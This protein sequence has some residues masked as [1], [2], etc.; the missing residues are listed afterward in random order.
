MEGRV[1][2]EVAGGHQRSQE[3]GSSLAFDGRVGEYRAL[4]K[5]DGSDIGA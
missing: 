1:A 3:G 4:S 2:L 5:E